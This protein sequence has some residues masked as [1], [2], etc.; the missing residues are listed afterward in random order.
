MGPL[1]V[2]LWGWSEFSCP[3]QRLGH[4]QPALVLVEADLH[5]RESARVI[6]D[7]LS[8]VE[9][10]DASGVS[11]VAFERIK[12][13]TVRAVTDTGHLV[14]VQQVVCVEGH[15]ASA[16]E[17]PGLI[18]PVDRWYHYPLDRVFGVVTLKLDH[19][20]VSVLVAQSRMSV[21]PALLDEAATAPP[22]SERP[23][24]L[25]SGDTEL[26]PVLVNLGVGAGPAVDQLETNEHRHDLGKG[27]Q[28]G[29]RIHHSNRVPRFAFESE[30]FRI[31][32]RDF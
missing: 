13:L 25:D 26:V 19:D 4:Q 17:N 10:D 22:V 23:V 6:L 27:R 16:V 12:E 32:S 29:H 21:R 15:P 28:M 11:G 14:L 2:V 30:H 18:S 7:M 5:P 3:D 1:V 9:V 20:Q 31:K 24:V 8:T